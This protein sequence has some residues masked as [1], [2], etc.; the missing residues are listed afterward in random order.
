M[1]FT[2]EQVETKNVTRDC[3]TVAI[4]IVNGQYPGPSV[5][6]NEGD[7]LIITVTSKVDT[8]VTIHW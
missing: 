5:H 3:E 6:V 2:I 7:T 4:A 1:K 8:D